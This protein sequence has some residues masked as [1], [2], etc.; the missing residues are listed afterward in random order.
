MLELLDH[1]TNDTFITIDDTTRGSEE[2]EAWS[3]FYE[4]LEEDSE[5]GNLMEEC[6]DLEPSVKRRRV[7]KPTMDVSQFMLKVEEMF[8]SSGD[9][10][11]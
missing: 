8:E 1:E 11:R 9:C 2:G 10:F 3:R 5:E 7:M 6:E 4:Q